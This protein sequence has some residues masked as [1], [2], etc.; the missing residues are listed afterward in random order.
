MNTNKIPAL[1]PDIIWRIL[2]DG[3]V[4][5]TPRAGNVRVLNRVGTAIWQLIDGQRSLAEIESQL[6][7]TYDVPVNQARSDLSSFMEELARRD[8][9][10]W[11]K[12]NQPS[13]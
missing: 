10:V 5:V 3:A 4:I 9:I 2:D 13:G 7:H 6:I 1:H 12:E 8:M 11:K